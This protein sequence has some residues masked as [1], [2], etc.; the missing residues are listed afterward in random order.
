MLAQKFWC[1][2][3]VTYKFA[4]SSLAVPSMPCSEIGGEWPYSCLL[5]GVASRIYSIHHFYVV[6]SSFFE[7]YF[8]R[9]GTISFNSTNTVAGS[10]KSRFILSESLWCSYRIVL[11]LLL[12]GRIP[13][14]N[15]SEKSDFYTV[16]SLS[17]VVHAFPTPMSTSLSIDVTLLPRY[18]ICS[19]KS[20]WLVFF[21]MMDLCY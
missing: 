4:P 16:S 1:V 10:K 5:W 3:K 17:A 9:A 6:S 12:L 13:C 7:E 15:L 2:Q 19:T 11:T 14:F 18:T 21:E 8:L 20:R